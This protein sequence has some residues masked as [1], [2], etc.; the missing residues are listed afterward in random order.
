MI[1]HDLPKLLETIYEQMLRQLQKSI[2]LKQTDI[3]M[4]AV[5][6]EVEGIAHEVMGLFCA[7]KLMLINWYSHSTGM[8]IR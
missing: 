4:G 7:G 6:V 5:V 8:K 3:H 1:I 2:V